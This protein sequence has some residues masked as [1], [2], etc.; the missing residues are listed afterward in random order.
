[1]L[2]SRLPF[3]IS[4]GT[5]LCF[6]AS[7]WAAPARILVLGTDAKPLAGAPVRVLERLDYYKPLPPR[8]LVTD[9]NGVVILEI[10]EAK[11][12]RHSYAVR[13]LVPGFAVA[14]RNIEAGETK[15]QLQAA[16]KWG[17]VVLDAAQ[18]PVAGAALRLSGWTPEKW[19]V[20]NAAT[21]LDSSLGLDA[22]TDAQG[23]YHFDNLPTSGR[24][25]LEIND[26]RFQKAT[27]SLDLAQK[28]A[29]PLFVKA[30]GTVTGRIVTPDGKPLG[31]IP[32][33]V[34]SAG[35]F[36]NYQAAPDGTFSIG[37]LRPDA[38][39]LRAFT[40]AD[41]WVLKELA[42]EPLQGG[43]TRRLPDWV[44]SRAL[45]VTGQVVDAVS[46]KPLPSVR[47]EIMAE[48]QGRV[49]TDAQGRFKALTSRDIYFARLRS[50]THVEKTIQ[51]VS[52]PQ[53][54]AQYD[55]GTIALAPGTRIAGTVR[56]EKG[57]APRYF[58]FNL[59][60]KEKGFSEQVGA[61]DGVFT[62]LA[63]PAGTYNLAA[64]GQEIISPKT[65]TVP[66]AGRS[67][68]PLE[69]IVKPEADVPSQIGSLAG[70]V[71][72][73]AG[74]PVAGAKVMFKGS[75]NMGIP[76]IEAISGADG[77]WSEL[78]VDQDKPEF[79]GIERPGFVLGKGGEVSRVA[80]NWQVGDIVLQ[81][82]GQI[83]SGRVLQAGQPVAGA[84]VA[85]AGNN[86]REPA[87]T[88]ATGTFR[89]EDLPQGEIELLAASA[90]G[91][92]ALK[93][94]GDA[95][96]VTLNLEAVPV[97]DARA[98]ANDLV[99]EQP[100]RGDWRLAWNIFGAPAMEVIALRADKALDANDQ[101]VA[102]RGS[103]HL[104]VYF[105]DL[106]RR[107]AARLL[108]RGP[109]LLPIFRA[110]SAKT[111]AEAILA[112]VQAA[113]S[114]VE[115]HKA[116]AVWLEREKAATRGINTQSV[117]QLLA[118]AEVAT[119]LER[120]DAA[121]LL[122]LA[123][124]FAVQLP[125]KVRRD[126]ADNWGH[127]VARIGQD[128]L[129][130]LLQDLEDVPRFLALGGAVRALSRGGDVQNARLG[131]KKMEE[132]Q[133]SRAIKAADLAER[134]PN[135]RKFESANLL[136][137]ARVELA[138]ALAP[139]DAAAALEIAGDTGNANNTMQQL[140]ALLQIGAAAHRAGN[141]EVAALALRRVTDA[142]YS[143]DHGGRAAA[144]AMGFNPRLGAQLFQKSLQRAAPT[145]DNRRYQPSVASWAFEQAPF[146]A[147]LARVILERE[148]SWRLPAYQAAEAAKKAQ[149]SYNQQ[150]SHIV[151][152][153]WAMSVFDP[154]RAL[155]WIKALPEKKYGYG[156]SKAL[157]AA[158]L[159][160]R[161]EQRIN[162][163]Q[164]LNWEAPDY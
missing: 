27:Y 4:L 9:A 65:I 158:T 152:L 18:K 141:D 24:A 58:Y 54:A 72:D 87:T 138:R 98:L 115:A 102:G 3:L 129:D 86:W 122:D 80:A 126:N 121:T 154:T 63:V 84:R 143:A 163:N 157:I 95:R 114:D 36:Q 73:G 124:T 8:D 30:G 162:F 56:D 85:I 133:L 6:S 45:E 110:G 5:L 78:F 144:I 156:Q 62:P 127:K 131:L 107:D 60:N 23:R 39:S 101:P 40:V 151:Y 76:T 123:L 100:E 11:T 12:P 149:N 25:L 99:R 19:S 75:P 71:V 57:A 146:D 20:S 44:A 112:R 13:V 37:G 104:S 50:E 134:E 136:S 106:A 88:D 17:G 117:A 93:T 164:Y 14:G 94:R 21:T 51:N 130:L 67:F 105:A 81:P 147:A 48:A 35:A 125:E 161:P 140:D 90:T 111:Q 89:F 137:S 15:F 145:D 159:W 108:E 91:F 47:V 148:W 83:W 69:V 22:I 64:Q 16:Q 120:P 135:G 32:I 128:A 26:P 31:D 74:Q 66:A 33:G 42:F 77:R 28:E 29:P 34:L 132:L 68:A 118:M 155:E 1:M 46:K 61:V 55:F 116:A 70:R 150:E 59:E 2:F 139:T 96:D 109:Q 160:A 38:T 7:L 119:K 103:Y 53:G 79:L 113:S 49:V 142:Q 92:T 43:E 97:V 41:G 82:S 153:A 52:I 10:D